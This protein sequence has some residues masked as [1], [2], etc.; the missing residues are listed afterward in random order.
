M[1]ENGFENV[2]NKL[3]TGDVLTYTKKEVLHSMKSSLHRTKISMNMLLEMN[4][5]DWF[6]TLTF[7]KDKIDR[8]N[9]K[10]VFDAYQKYINNIK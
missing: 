4:D 2:K 7:D 1:A 6:C 3:E 8:M 5:F 10:V 9:D